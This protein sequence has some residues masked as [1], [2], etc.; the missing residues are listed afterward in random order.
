MRAQNA[1]AAIAMTSA[2]SAA[3]PPRT[4]VSPLAGLGEHLQHLALAARQPDRLVSPARLAVRRVDVQRAELDAGLR[5]RST[6][7]PN[8]SVEPRQ[9]LPF[10]IAPC[11]TSSLPRSSSSVARID[12]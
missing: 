8:G 7:A 10:W 9:R 11:R 6:R 12:E 5:R 4:V 2:A 1:V 3:T